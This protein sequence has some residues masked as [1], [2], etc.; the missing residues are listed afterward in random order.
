MPSYHVS[1]CIEN[2][3]IMAA[4]ILVV[5]M[6]LFF[7]SINAG[8]YDDMFALHTDVLT[9]YSKHIRPVTNQ[10]SPMYVTFV[11]SM[12]YFLDFDAVTGR[13]TV[14][15]SIYVGWIDGK[16]TWN[17]ANYGNIQTSYFSHTQVWTPGLIIST[18]V[19]SDSLT[20][21]SSITV[22]SSGYASTIYTKVVTSSCSPDIT[23][24]PYDV[25]NCSLVF[26]VMEPYSVV[27]LNVPTNADYYEFTDNLFWEMSRTKTEKY[28]ASNYTA[29][30][31]ISYSLERRPTY[32]LYTIVLPV[33]LL[34]FVTLL[35]F[36]LPAESGERVSFATTMLLTLTM[37]MTIMSDS[38]P[39]TSDPVSILTVSLM[40]KLIISAIIV[41][42]V[43]ITLCVYNS[44]EDRPIPTWMVYS[45]N[46][47]PKRVVQSD[48]D[49]VGDILDPN[50]KRP[51]VT[52]QIIGKRL[53]IAFLVLFLAIMLIETI[54]N[55]VRISYRL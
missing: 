46:I 8:T 21:T 30:V 45:C 42:C 40:I 17:P 24:Y 25:H 32:L 51:A 28:Y 52:W 29:M 54:Y 2:N 3:I 20:P 50:S 33:C 38:I 14:L 34:N 18:S 7:G 23:Y 1:T 35:A 19:D 4:T 5:S 44:S 36:I 9:N 10:D 49:V 55:T 37:Y 13:F 15:A 47:K 22:Y 48:K 6:C 41:L 12:P 26:S 11:F 53:D 27:D 31:E 16:L 39:N 43:I